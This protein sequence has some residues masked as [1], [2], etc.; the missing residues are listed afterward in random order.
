MS[1]ALYT[2][3]LID[4]RVKP[5]VC[6]IRTWAKY[7]SITKE[8]PGPWI[9]NHS[10]TLLVLFYLQTEKIL[11]SLNIIEFS[12]SKCVHQK[13]FYACIIL[14]LIFLFTGNSIAAHETNCHQ[15]SD[16]QSL[17]NLLYGFFQYYNS[18]NFDE[19]AICV[20]EAKIKAKLTSS[21]MHIYN[22][23]NEDLNISRNIKTKELIHMKTHI[24]T[25]LRIL[26]KSDYN[27]L[28]LLGLSCKGTLKYTVTSDD[29][30]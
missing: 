23:Y 11:P 16:D 27:I 22:P 7:M 29:S 25:A 5:L 14:N 17:Y 18:F 4:W 24:Q 1:E 15:Q 3:G 30:M 8:N 21:P 28:N 12:K 6:T 13:Y 20:R 9:T 26:D 2:Y 19:C 10:L